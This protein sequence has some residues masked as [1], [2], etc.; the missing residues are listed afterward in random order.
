MAEVS[1][2]Q[3]A[4][5][6][7]GKS[8]SPIISIPRALQAPPVTAW[9]FSRLLD[10]E[11]CAYR[12]FLASVL[13][14]AR[15]DYPAKHPLVIGQKMHEDAEHYIRGAGDHVPKSL[16]KSAAELMFCRDMYE[17]GKAT[18][19]EDWGFDSEWAAVGWM[20]PNIWL[21]VK[22][23]VTVRLDQTSLLIIDWKSGKSSGSEVRQMQQAQLYAIS[24]FMK[25][26]EVTDLSVT[27]AFFKDGKT[28]PERSSANY[29]RAKSPKYVKRWTERATVL[30]NC[31]DFRPEPNRMNCKYCPYGPNESGTGQCAFG[32]ES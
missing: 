7:K 22:C 17:Q 10:F 14:A 19:E 21:R 13:R 26:P 20:D 18:V 3:F 25:Y 1:W 23:D 8:S 5:E 16:I 32:V 30:T 9:S 15:P 6:D 29:T 4:D 24:A 28:W 27:F 2:F 31:T 12:V 11:S